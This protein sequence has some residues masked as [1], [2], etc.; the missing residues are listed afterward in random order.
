MLEL[1][2]VVLPGRL[3][4]C[5]FQAREGE[6][7]GLVG[8]TGAGKSS[9]L[10]VLCG[11]ERPR[12]G[13][14]LLE[15]K[16]ASPARLKALCGLVGAPV[17]PGDLGVGAWLKLWAGVDGLPPGERA[18]RLQE[19]SQRFGVGWS[20]PVAQLSAGQRARLE[21]ARAWARRP[22]V[23][24]L[25][26]PDAHLDGEGLRALTSA[27]REAAASGLTVVLCSNAPHLPSSVC[28]RVLCMRDGAVEHTL[29][30]S[31]ETF[32]AGIADALGWSA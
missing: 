2:G 21:L 23:F 19:A 5:D 4:R 9:A 16:D 8:P 25:D 18:D 17:G 11:L 24:L 27:L 7:L 22:R 13:R 32:A 20:G 31:D 12:R 14:V 3:D 30:R 15:G 1:R 10:E 6:I 26:A 29:S 28:D